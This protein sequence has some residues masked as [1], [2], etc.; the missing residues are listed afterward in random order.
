MRTELR[1]VCSRE[2]FCHVFG[3]ISIHE[4]EE[5]PAWVRRTGEKWWRG[6]VK[7]GFLDENC[8]LH[9][10]GEPERWYNRGPFALQA[11]RH[12]RYLEG[13]R[14]PEAMDEPEAAAL[15]YVANA[16]R[17]CEKRQKCTCEERAP[18]FFGALLY[19]NRSPWAQV[20]SIARQCGPRP[21]PIYALAVIRTPWHWA[22]KV[23]ARR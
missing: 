4:L 23:Y 9:A 10:L 2:S 18:L 19:Q 13:C 21:W 11:G 5:R 6:A 20:Q 8:P 22:K 14:G 12:L 17:L 16:E 15:A 1:N 3:E 7:R